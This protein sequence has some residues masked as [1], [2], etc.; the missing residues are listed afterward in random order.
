MQE[1]NLEEMLNEMI[2]DEQESQAFLGGRLWTPKPGYVQHFSK[3]L[4]TDEE[5]VDAFIHT[6]SHWYE[7]RTNTLFGY[8]DEVKA[9]LVRCLKEND[10]PDPEIASLDQAQLIYAEMKFSN[11][12]TGPEGMFTEYHPKGI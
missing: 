6:T 10:E 4:F 3:T 12:W 1:S 11:E 9:E 2:A 5:L 7:D 8:Q